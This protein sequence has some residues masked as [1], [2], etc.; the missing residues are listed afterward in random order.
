MAF[1]YTYVLKC[2]VDN[3][4]S[5]LYIGYTFDLRNRLYLHKN[6]KVPSTKKYASVEL[7]YYEACK[8]KDDAIL[9]E[10]ALKTGYGRAFLKNRLKS[11]KLRV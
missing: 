5:N 9:R 3:H 10:K 1:Y 7:I 2:L 6:K 4:L 11:Q 8:A